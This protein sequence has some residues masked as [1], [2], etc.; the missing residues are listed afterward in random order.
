MVTASVPKFTVP[1]CGFSIDMATRT[2]S[3]D[4]DLL[5]K[6]SGTMLP[7]V[8]GCSPWASGFTVACEMLGLGTEDIS[9]RP[10][11]RTGHV[12]ESKVIDYLGR[13]YSDMGLFLPAEEVY[14]ERKGEHGDWSPD[15]DDGSFT[16][17]VDGLLM[18]PEGEDYILEIKTSANDRA[19]EDGVPEY[20]WWQVAL[21]DRF[22]AH[23]GVA[24]LARG[25]VDRQVYDDPESWA[26]SDDNVTLYRVELDQGVVEDGIARAREWRDGLARTRTT[27]PSDPSRS[28]D[29]LLY[30]HLCGLASCE[31]SF[32]DILEEYGH[33][34]GRR[35]ELD[36]ET[37]WLREKE[38]SLKGLVC[39]H[40]A[41]KGIEQAE[42]RSGRFEVRM[43]T[44][45]RRTVD[46]KLMEQ[47]GIDPQPYLKETNYRTLRIRESKERD[48][49]Q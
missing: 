18:T 34:H 25:R 47:A 17:H 3:A 4:G 32:E 19:W 5:G 48:I 8:L 35:L 2:V 45:V 40:M 10:A 39:D 29:E 30:N 27:P 23:K 13:R 28:A 1:R 11:V 9:D 43:Q 22:I 14:G 42:S 37:R 16:G 12:L 26:P 7:G 24:Y 36:E 15:F 33:V 31:T 20:Y 6:I 49:W 41:R 38:E 21:Y 44:R 46:A